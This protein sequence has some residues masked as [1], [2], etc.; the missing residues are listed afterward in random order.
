MTVAHLR[1]A[2]T[3]PVSSSKVT[4][5]PRRIRASPM[6]CGASLHADPLHHSLPHTSA[7]ALA[8][9]GVRVV[10]D[11]KNASGAGE[12]V[13]LP[14][15]HGTS[16]LTCVVMTRCEVRLWCGGLREWMPGF[17]SCFRLWHYHLEGSSRPST[18][19]QRCP[20]PQWPMGDSGRES[21]LAF[22]GKNSLDLGAS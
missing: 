11:L 14:P 13:P 10:G 2:G 4:A 6:V 3:S 22:G 15:T 5:T 12:H 17:T 1:N 19:C 18:P 7:Q 20:G 16:P 9:P 8:P 21:V